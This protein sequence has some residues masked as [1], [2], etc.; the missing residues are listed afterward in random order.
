MRV[1]CNQS[2]DTSTQRPGPHSWVHVGGSWCHGE[3]EVKWSVT[4]KLS[5][6]IAISELW[7]LHLLSQLRGQ[8]WSIVL[9]PH[10]RQMLKSFIDCFCQGSTDMFYFGGHKDIYY[11]HFLI[12]YNYL[13]G[14]DIF[15][16]NQKRST[17]F[18]FTGIGIK[19]VL[20]GSREHLHH[21]CKH[22]C[23]EVTQIQQTRKATLST[24]CALTLPASDSSHYL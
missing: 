18:S 20:S 13:T 22:L 3:M 7:H 14:S 8:G 12:F 21:V 11:F 10:R 4:R 15:L 1:R 19:N 9:H 2:P 23:S 16:V 24:R 17:L 5:L 6:S